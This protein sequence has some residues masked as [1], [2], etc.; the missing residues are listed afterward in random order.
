MAF[1]R[2]WCA[3]CHGPGSARAC[4]CVPSR[5]DPRASGAGRPARH[6][7][8]APSSLAVMAPTPAAPR[9]G[10]G[11]RVDLRLGRLD[12]MQLKEATSR[13]M[14]RA[15]PTSDAEHR[16]PSGERRRAERH[17]AAAG[18]CARAASIAPGRSRRRAAR[19]VDDAAAAPPWPLVAGLADADGARGTGEEV[20]PG[21]TT[22]RAAAS[23]SS[24]RASRSAPPA[25]CCGGGAQRP[26][27]VDCFKLVLHCIMIVTIVVPPSAHGASLAVQNSLI[28]L[29]RHGG[30]VRSGG[31]GGSPAKLLLLLLRQDGHAQYVGRH[32]RRRRSP[33]P[34]PPTSAATRRRRR[35]CGERR[36]GRR[37]AVE[38]G[39]SWL[40]VKRRRSCSAAATS[41]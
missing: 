17:E 40:S 41:S 21:T 37:R 8:S 11:E 9:L 25:T 6:Q 38:R 16:P 2:L 24:C 36:G 35:R 34:T 1:L 23:S 39:W 33:P 5:V 3:R 10:G 4:P 13:A 12:A 30:S 28:A 20:R 32:G 14:R 18:D 15:A 29:H 19:S 7:R 27:A 22:R 26:V 31:G